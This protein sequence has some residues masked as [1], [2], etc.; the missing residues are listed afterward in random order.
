MVQPLGPG[1][2]LAGTRPASF[3]TRTSRHVY[4]DQPGTL[5]LASIHSPDG[6]DTESNGSLFGGS[7]PICL[8]FSLL[9]RSKEV[10]RT[11]KVCA[12]SSADLFARVFLDVTAHTLD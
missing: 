8:C 11:A 6:R 7:S 5:G 4:R 2:P 1:A 3:I 10:C 12:P 9:R